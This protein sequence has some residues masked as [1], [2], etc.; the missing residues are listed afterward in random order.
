MQTLGGGEG[1]G[2]G[3]GLRVARHNTNFNH[4][5]PLGQPQL[6]QLPHLSLNA[7]ISNVL[8]LNVPTPYNVPYHHHDPLIVYHNIRSGL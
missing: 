8:P 3:E 2:E 6:P 4:Y 1:E 7:P 5:H